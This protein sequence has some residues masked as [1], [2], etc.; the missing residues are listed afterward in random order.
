MILDLRGNPGGYLKSAI[1]IADEFLPPGKLI[2][3]TEG[4]A[5][6]RENFH[7]T[8]K[9]DFIKGDLAV[10]ID[11]GSASA[12][13]IVSGAIQDLDRGVIIGRRSFGKGL[14]QEQSE[15]PDGSAVRLTVARYYTP[16]GR[17]IQKPYEDD[18]DAYENEIIRRMQHG[19]LL[20]SDSIHFP[21]SLKYTTPKG[22]TV[23]GGGGI[24]PDIFVPLD[25]AGVSGFYT[26]INGLGVINQFAYD[27]LDQNRNNLEKYRSFNDF[28]RNFQ[29]TTDIY[30]Q[31]VHSSRKAGVNSNDGVEMARPFISNQFKALI[32]R[33]LWGNEGFFS[34][35]QT[36]DKTIQKA[37]EILS[38]AK[39][40]KAQ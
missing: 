31:L 39:D 23:Y 21:D 8:S 24:M 11:E 19:E 14:V 20:H 1:E 35:L 26:E 27:Y 33:Q 4:H 17:C 7:S 16:T 34:V 40:D 9:G 5:R 15:F 22:K 32:A 10:L 37:I 6:P 29:V 2:V 30:A 36:Q 28:N 18:Y 25:T 13:E 12:S 3:Y 38:S